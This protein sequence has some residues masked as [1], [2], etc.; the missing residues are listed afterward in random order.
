[1]GIGF[2]GDTGF[3]LQP[4]VSLEVAALLEE[5][6]GVA[7]ERVAERYGVPPEE[8]EVMNSAPAEYPLLGITVFDFKVANLNELEFYLVTLDEAGEELDSDALRAAAQEAYRLTY[9]RLDVE[10]ANY[11]E[12]AT[13]DELINVAICFHSV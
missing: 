13:E 1:M 6:E 9:G 3:A 4:P 10:L 5:L 2:L 7:I 11:L 12:G 8:L